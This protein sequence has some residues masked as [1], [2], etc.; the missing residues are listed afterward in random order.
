MPVANRNPTFRPSAVTRHRTHPPKEVLSHG[1]L[2][3]LGTAM[4]K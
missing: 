4:G 1:L 3:K 2:E